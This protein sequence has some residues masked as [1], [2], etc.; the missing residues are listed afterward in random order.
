MIHDKA[1]ADC[2]SEVDNQSCILSK[3]RN[4]STVKR[5]PTMQMEA[6][7]EASRSQVV[8]RSCAQIV[9]DQNFIASRDEAI[10]QV[11]A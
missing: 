6:T 7:R 2:C 8:L 9:K 5:T 4:E 3:A 1:N 10:S 11:R